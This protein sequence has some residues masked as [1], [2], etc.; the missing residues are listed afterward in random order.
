MPETVFKENSQFQ[1]LLSIKLTPELK[2]E[3]YARELER[4][5]QDL[6]KKNGLKVGD[7][8]DLYYNTTAASLE[9]A[10][11]NKFDRKKTF[12]VQ[13]KKELEVE[14]DIEAQLLIED[15]AIW[16]GIQKV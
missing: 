10:L 1:I 8:I 9:M 14:P 13:V 4:Q 15:K 6:R 12:V 16:V 3:G 5:V 2:E 7:L 11:I